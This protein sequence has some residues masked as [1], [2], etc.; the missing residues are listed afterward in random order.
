M[1]QTDANF[2]DETHTSDDVSEKTAMKPHIAN[3]V[4]SDLHQM[5][6]K[7]VLLSLLVLGTSAFFF[8]RRTSAAAQSDLEVSFGEQGLERLTYHGVVLEDVKQSPSDAFH[9]WHMKT[10]DLQGKVLSSGQYGWGESNNGKHWDRAEQTWTYSFSWGSI[11]FHFKQDGDTLDM[12]VTE[13]NSAE[14][15]VIFDGASIFPLALHFP[16][17]PAGFKEA[18]YSQIA[19]N[20]TAPSVT[21]A[22]Y[23]RGAVAAVVPDGSR[24]LYSGFQPSG[25]PNAYA[26]LISGTPPDGLAA[27]RP[28][29]D[30]SLKP[31]QTETF[32]VSLRFAPDAKQIDPRISDVYANWSKAWPARLKWTDRRP[33][34]TIYLASAP[35]EKEAGATDPTRNPRRFFVSSGGADLDVRTPDGLAR[36][37]TRVLRYAAE[38]AHNLDRLHAQ[39]AITWDIEGEQHPHATSYVCSPDQIAETAPEMESIVAD[40]SSPYKGM[41]LDDA[42]FKTLRDA[43]QRVGVCI[44][45]QHFTARADGTA[46]QVTLPNSEVVSELIRKMRYAHDRWGATLF[47]LDSTVQADGG[48]LN[49]QIVQQAAAALPD[50]LLIPEE[51]TPR[52]YAYT[53]PFLTFLFHTDLGTDPVIHRYYRDAFSVNLINDVDPSKLASY[54]AQLTDSV[55]HGDIL[56]VHADYWHPNNDT[57]LA[58][59]RDAAVSTAPQTAPSGR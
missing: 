44:R 14:S 35:S 6:R 38:A 27:F 30:R 53:A 42:Y 18:S 52:Y 40:A 33:I 7:L 13:T 45:P 15:G 50:S 21:V 43:G 28:H 48:T 37:Q 8:A 19:D 57:V 16:E 49:P 26:P 54:K 22:D 10:T 23:D 25:A 32:T 4:R 12:I 9:I 41:K 24:P 36:F 29:I 3:L 34:G 11:R 2:E 58:I 1:L 56:M 5:A 55:R 31:G 59:Y 39:G 20:I 17:L 51:S 47:Y 46:E